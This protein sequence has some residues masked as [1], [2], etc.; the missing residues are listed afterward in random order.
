MLPHSAPSQTRLFKKYLGTIWEAFG[1]F[2]AEE[3]SEKHLEVRSQKL[4][5]LSAKMQKHIDMLLLHHVF[6]AQITKCYKL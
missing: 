3:A 5:P 1:E 6:V 4:Q 2:E